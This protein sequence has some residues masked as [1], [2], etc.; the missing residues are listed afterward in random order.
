MAAVAASQGVL[1][2]ARLSASCRLGRAL[3]RANG[4]AAQRLPRRR[5]QSAALPATEATAGS[6][7]LQ[8]AHAGGS[9]SSSVS[10]RF[11][12][13]Q[14]DY[15]GLWANTTFEE[16][17]VHPALV[18]SL[19]VQGITRP[20]VVQAE[21]FRPLSN[22]RDT[23]LRAETGSG[24]TLAYLLPLINRIYHL[25]DL[26]R[27]LAEEDPTADNPLQKSRPWIVLVPSL[28]L[29]A[30]ILAMLEAIDVDRLVGA[31]SLQRLFTWKALGSEFQRR[32]SFQEPKLKERTSVHLPFAKASKEGSSSN[33]FDNPYV[34]MAPRI[35]WG[36]TD[37]VVTTPFALS[38]EL[39]RMKEDGMYPAC[40]IMDEADFLVDNVHRSHIF[41]L[42]ATLR[43]RLKIRQPDEPRTRL[44]ELL[45][46][47][48]VFAAATMVHIGPFSVGN[49]IIERFCTAHVVETK[50]FHRLPA[51]LGLDNVRWVQGSSDWD[52]RVE[53]LVEILREI[54]C[55]RTLIFVNTVHNCHVLLGFLREAGW[56]V[57]GFM[58][59]WQGK[60][61][62]R[63]KDAK[64]F[65]DGEV[66]MLVATEFGGR[67]IDWFEVDHVINF[68]MPNGA[69][70]W[71]HRVGRTGRMGKRGLVTNFVSASHVRDQRLSEIIKLRLTA[72]KDLHAAFSRKRSLRRKLRNADGEEASY[73]AEAGGLQAEDGRFRL[74]GGMELYEEGLAASSSS[75][76]AA[77]KGGGEA[78]EAEGTLLGYVPTF[79]DPG[80]MGQRLRKE[81]RGR[82]R[83]AVAQVDDPEGAEEEEE[84]DE[85]S[86]A[87]FRKRLLDSD[88]EDEGELSDDLENLGGGGRRDSFSAPGASPDD[89]DG[90]EWS[91]LSDDGPESS[92]VVGPKARRDVLE[93]ATTR[94][95][96]ATGRPTSRPEW[97]ARRQGRRKGLGIEASSRA[98]A[99][100]NYSDKDDELLL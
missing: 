49:M 36:A 37:V 98:A 68:Q 27:K 13:L 42:F 81:A 9:A 40:I 64:K 77:G 97:A 17:G 62:P 59:G 16:L 38:S 23:V 72:G 61:G 63:F 52:R 22:G 96:R 33:P 31:Q 73:G 12:S 8:R 88:S 5:P 50:N 20:T 75:R 25:H 65:V 69:A 89:G 11:S 29:C 10:R 4:E 1:R 45:P 2:S 66:K 26:A 48:F 34:L 15:D 21:S 3:A 67:G 41:D 87:S 18:Q 79:E 39:E 19:A 91:M 76:S 46:T 32:E 30:Q 93:S 6:W 53:Q 95:D 55:E 35:R 86:L 57:A 71:L 78:A 100:R 92:A 24:K 7:P 74:H 90:F 51:S 58:K 80:V 70:Q 28:D 85:D 56:P 14:R 60:M 82:S 99:A 83:R 84:E 54:N 47:Q 43:P 94:S 44:P